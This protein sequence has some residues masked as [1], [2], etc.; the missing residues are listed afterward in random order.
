MLSLFFYTKIIKYT[1]LKNIYLHKS[2]GCEMYRDGGC[3]VYGK[4]TLQFDKDSVLIKSTSKRVGSSGNSKILI[5]DSTEN[6]K[7]YNY[8]LFC[9]FIYIPKSKSAL[10][11]AFYRLTKDGLNDI[12][13]KKLQF[14]KEYKYNE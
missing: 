13:S 7:K 11:F 4:T 2:E 12:L 6:F 10:E 5:N 8:Q 14:K 9:N 1:L 3:M